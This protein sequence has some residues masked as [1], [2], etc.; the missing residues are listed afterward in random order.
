MTQAAQSSGCSAVTFTYS[1]IAISGPGVVD[2]ALSLGLGGDRTVAIA[3]Q[4]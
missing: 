4:P 2:L 1:R 3:F